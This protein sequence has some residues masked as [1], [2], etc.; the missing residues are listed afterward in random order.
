MD[1][2]R[3][4]APVEWVGL[5][6]LLALGLA[7]LLSAA[8][9]VQGRAFGGALAQ[10]MVCAAR[11]AC[12]AERRTA[13][14]AGQAAAGAAAATRASPFPATD[15]R[16]RL[17]A[18]RRARGLAAAIPRERAASAFRALRGLRAVARRAW[19]LCLGYRRYRYELAHPELTITG[20]AMPVEEALRIAND[21]VNP[22]AFIGEE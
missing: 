18:A 8:S 7:A 2:E 11:A 3:G 14:P 17:A 9:R 4:Q 20:R 16:T 19:I 22:L 21:C 6:L 15:R 13:G 12:E 1:S 5:L 10:R